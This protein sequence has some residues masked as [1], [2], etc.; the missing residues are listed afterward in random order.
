[1][2]AERRR[3][4]RRAAGTRGRLAPADCLRAWRVALLIGFWRAGGPAARGAGAAALGRG[5]VVGY[6]IAQGS[7]QH[8]SLAGRMEPNAAIL[9]AANGAAA[10]ALGLVLGLSWADWRT[11]RRVWLSDPERLLAAPPPREG[12]HALALGLAGGA[13]LVA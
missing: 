5:R 2:A 13:G 11:R 6:T 4:S 10:A 1:P 3:A 9:I 12:L 8:G 7:S